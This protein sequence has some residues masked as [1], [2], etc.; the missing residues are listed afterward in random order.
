M[1]VVVGE[2]TAL[3]TPTPGDSSA[4]IEING[5]QV[6]VSDVELAQ[7]DDR[8]GNVIA[9][10]VASASGAVRMYLPQHDI[11]VQYDGPAV[12]VKV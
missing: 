12:K 7:W 6:S 1:L 8:K 4:N 11:E 10:M 9:Q 3:L 5:K 2:S